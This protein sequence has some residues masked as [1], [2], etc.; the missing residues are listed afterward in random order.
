MA[1]HGGFG[2]IDVFC[3][4]KGRFVFSYSLYVKVTP[5]PST[6]KFDIY[7]IYELEVFIRGTT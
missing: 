5:P 3:Y 7:K 2:T 6:L 4:H 1:E